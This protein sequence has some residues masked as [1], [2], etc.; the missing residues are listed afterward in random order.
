MDVNTSLIGLSLTAYNRCRPNRREL[1]LRLRTNAS[2]SA[3]VRVGIKSQIF[4]LVKRFKI[5]LLAPKERA[6]PTWEFGH[7]L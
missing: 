6:V 4:V 2:Y 3:V 1:L 5:R 7:S